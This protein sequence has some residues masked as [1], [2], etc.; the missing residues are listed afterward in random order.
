[1]GA[2]SQSVNHSSPT[3]SQPCV[4]NNLKIKVRELFIF[5]AGDTI[6]AVP[7]HVATQFNLQKV[8][9]YRNEKSPPPIFFKNKEVF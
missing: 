1:M 6:P 3:P 2:F 9:D 4:I 7:G 8:L 5:Y